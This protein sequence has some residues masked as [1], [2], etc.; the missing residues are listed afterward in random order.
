VRKNLAVLYDFDEEDRG[1][2]DAY[3]A[4][5]VDRLVGV[6]GKA[7]DDLAPAQLSVG[8]G[9]VGFAVNRREPTPRA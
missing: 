3:G 6:V 9:A 1:R 8:H 2:V 4:D 5:L 7:L